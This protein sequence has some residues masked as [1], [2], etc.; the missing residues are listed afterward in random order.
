MHPFENKLQRAI[1]GLKRS[2]DTMPHPATCGFESVLCQIPINCDLLMPSGHI[3]SPGI[4]EHNP[5]FT[6]RS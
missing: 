5:F 6:Y 4:E 2:S 1:L 3:P